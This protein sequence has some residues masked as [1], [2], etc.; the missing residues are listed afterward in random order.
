VKGR[1]SLIPTAALP[2]VFSYIA[3][4]LKNFGQTPIKIGGIEN[5]IHMLI[6]YS[7]SQPLPDLVREIKSLTTKFIN[8]SHLT[9]FLFSWQRGYSC[10]SYSQSH[11][12]AV[13]NY[14]EHQYEHH[15]NQTLRDEIISIYQKY[16]VEFHEEF[17]FDEA[18]DL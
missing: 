8:N 13:K 10:F 4:A 15:R 5:H 9:P 17:L 16:G 6:S 3:A 11:I 12:P 18:N 1:E 2:R 14:I 7:P